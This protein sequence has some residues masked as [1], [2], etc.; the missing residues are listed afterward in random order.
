MSCASGIL[1][2]VPA[3]AR[4]KTIETWCSKTPRISSARAVQ[5]FTVVPVALLRTLLGKSILVIAEESLHKLQLP[6]LRCYTEASPTEKDTDDD[7][8]V[9]ALL[10]FRVHPTHLSVPRP[11]F[12]LRL[13]AQRLPLKRAEWPAKRRGKVHGAGLGLRWVPFSSP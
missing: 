4:A 6:C 9:V 10:V 3:G 2:I 1:H 12:L 13:K 11:Q 7:D 8:L 5:I